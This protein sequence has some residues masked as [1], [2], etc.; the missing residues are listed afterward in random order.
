MAKKKT[1]PLHSAPWWDALRRMMDSM[2]PTTDPPWVVANQ[3][4]RVEGFECVTTEDVRVVAWHLGWRKPGW[5]KPTESQGQVQRR[6]PR[7]LKGVA[8][9]TPVFPEMQV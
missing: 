6:R 9:R 1:Y 4:I 5:G 7:S 3:I 8:A 2:G